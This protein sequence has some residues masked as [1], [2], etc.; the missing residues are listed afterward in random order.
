MN[1]YLEHKKKPEA[2]VDFEELLEK[3]GK[4]K[5]IIIGY[6]IIYLYSKKQ[7]E[8]ELLCELII[9]LF[10]KNQLELSNIIDGY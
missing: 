6:L 1:E 9:Y 8:F 7:G 10:T 2:I 4:E 5:K 3:T